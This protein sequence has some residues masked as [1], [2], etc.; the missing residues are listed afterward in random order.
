MM[1]TGP[2]GWEDELMAWKN[3]DGFHRVTMGLT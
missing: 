3:R 2:I 1:K